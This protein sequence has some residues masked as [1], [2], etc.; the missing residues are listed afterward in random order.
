MP[1]NYNLHTAANTPAYTALDGGLRRYMSGVY[2]LMA[3]GMVVTA[4][5]AMGLAHMTA[6]NPQL[7]QLFYNSPLKWGLIFAPLVLV[8]LLSFNIH[9]LSTNTARLLFLVYA[10]IVGLSISSLFLV[11]TKASIAQVFFITAAT[12]GALSLYG[13]T[14]KRNLRPLGTFLFFA[15]F[16]LILA[17]LVNLFWH[18]AQFSFATSAIGILIFAGLTAFDTQNIKQMYYE[19]DSHEVMGRKITMGA[20][21]LYLDFL[22]MFIALMQILGIRNSSS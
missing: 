21:S 6:T 17:S 22:N 8:M 14:T 15:L 19:G 16:G 1:D 20:L 10:A 5:A 2:G 11:Y 4:I 9:R 3:L 18:N 12:F 7:A 13:Y